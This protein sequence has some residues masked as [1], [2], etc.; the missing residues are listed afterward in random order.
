[1]QTLTV[2]IGN[3]DNK[4]TQREWAV[5]TDTINKIIRNHSHEV[6]FHGY[7][8]SNSKYQNAAWVFIMHGVTEMDGIESLKEELAFQK[9][10]WRQESIALVYGTT[11]FI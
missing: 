4:L 1:M 5:F 2:L 6:H 11:E 9:R 3:S 7:S 10:Q 8:L